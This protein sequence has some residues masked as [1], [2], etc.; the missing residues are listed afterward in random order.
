MDAR[1]LKIV[2]LF[3]FS[4][5]LAAVFVAPGTAQST[6]LILPA[7]IEASLDGGGTADYTFTALS[8]AVISLSVRSADDTF[9]PIVTLLDN[10]GREVIANDDY[11]FPDTRNAL[12]EAISIPRT[13]TYTVRVTGYNGSSGAYT[14]RVYP[15]FS[16]IGVTE[17]FSRTG[18]WETIREDLN[19]NLADGALQMELSGVRSFGAA[20]Y[21]FVD[22][23]E[24]FYVQAQVLDVSNPSGWIVGITAR[25][26][27]E[28]YYA[29]LINNEGFWRFSLVQS[30]VETVLRDWTPHPNIVPGQQ[31]FTIGLMANT[32]GFDFYYNGGYIGSVADSTLTNPG[33][34]GLIV[35]T[36]GSLNSVTTAQIDNLVITTP[37]FVDGERV[38]PQALIVSA[39]A[40]MERA[41]ELRHN[42]NANGA[43]TLTV[44]ESTVEFARAGVNRLMLGRGTTYT[45]FVMGA[46]VQIQGARQGLAGCGLVVRYAGENDYAIAYLDQM[47]GY[48]ISE[49][50]SEE[51]LPG[52]FGQISEW[53]LGDSHH[54]LLIADASTLFYYIDGKFVGTLNYA[55]QAGEVG[56]AVVN[57]E[58]ITTTCR[59]TDLWLWRWE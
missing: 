24:D 51:F 55:S 44:P 11:N 18:G 19:A 29:L 14:L 28:N 7:T 1:Q 32:V 12:L 52:L 48:G 9:D 22:P 3:V 17:D 54:L 59:Y 38:I 34:V 15:G 21:Q 25:R 5:M 53:D 8:G 6:D 40:E 39:A 33:Q 56:T 30:G 43:M 36:R 4:V 35:A 31:T 45:N 50:Q 20:F 46:T 49:R 2:F 57:F 37:H 41:L 42:I 16:E 23:V 13:G 47:G 58:T 27:D 26:Q 10:T